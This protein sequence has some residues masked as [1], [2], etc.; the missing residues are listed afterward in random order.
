MSARIYID[1]R[2]LTWVA[3]RDS[4]I[5]NEFLQLDP[6]IGS[7]KRAIA[8]VENTKI[9]RITDTLFDR[10]VSDR[11]VAS[12]GYLLDGEPVIS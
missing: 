4:H 2:T 11:R 12:G 8:L 7:H 1:R 6:T 5:S 10:L 3:H 9:E